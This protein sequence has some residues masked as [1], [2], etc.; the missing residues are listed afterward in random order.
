MLKA[1]KG[2]KGIVTK[3]DEERE[4]LNKQRE[5]KAVRPEAVKKYPKILL[6]LRPFM[7]KSM[8]LDSRIIS[9]E[10][11]AETQKA[12][13]VKGQADMLDNLSFCV[14]CAKELTE[15]ASQITGMGRICAEKS[16]M[17]YDPQNILGASKKEREAI[18]RQFKQKLNNQTFERWIPKSQAEL[19]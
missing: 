8:N 3:A 2:Y 6:K 9:G 19:I 1:R 16:M 4:A 11:I 12:W 18:R 17:P 14:R 10:L 13:L 7:M 15:P 5:Q